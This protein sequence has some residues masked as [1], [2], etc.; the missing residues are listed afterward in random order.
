MMYIKKFL[1]QGISVLAAAALFCAVSAFPL[2]AAGAGISKVEK[3]YDIA[4]VFDNSGSMYADGSKAWCRAK[5]AM[6]IFASMLDYK[7][8]DRLTVYPMWEVTTDGSRP[9]TG[10][11]Y[12]PF[13]ITSLSDVDKISDLY[14]VHPS[15]T[16][17]APVREAYDGLKTSAASE[18]WLIVLTDGAF[19][20]RERTIWAG[21]EN[22]DLQAELSS[23]ADGNVKVQYLGIGEA[24]MLASDESK[25]FYAK[26]STDTS[27][28][29]DLISI[30]N[31]I[32][33]R[34]ELPAGYLAGNTLTL[35][36]SMRKLLVFAQGSGA[37]IVSLT[38]EN[39]RTIPVLQDSGQRKYSEIKALGYEDAAVDTDLAGQVVTFDSCPKGTYTLDC[40]GA[41]SVQVFY[42]PDVDIAIEL[43]DLEGVPID[44]FSQI[45]T[46][47]YILNYCI[48]DNVT[49]EDVT[50][51]VLMGGDVY[52]IASV[53][54]LGKDPI[55]VPN[56]GKIT[57]EPDD[58]TFITAYG[59]YLEDYTITSEG[60][61]AI[62]Q[63]LK[64]APPPAGTLRL[65]SDV[66]QPL[67]WYKTTDRDSWQPVK[68]TLSLDGA[69]LTD[70]QLD[71]LQLDIAF[72]PELSFE[73]EPVYGES[74]V[75]VY[76]KGADDTPTGFYRINAKASLFDPY[77]QE[78]SDDASSYFEIRMYDR[79]WRWLIWLVLLG[80][81]L[82]TFLFIMTRK[83]LPKS[84]MLEPR[85]T[86]FE[87]DFQ[88][89]EIENLRAAVK[90]SRK[91]KSLVI[92]TPN[93]V[94]YSAQCSARL[95]LKPI[96]KRF[97][98][99][100]DRR[101][102]VTGVSSANAYSI[103]IGAT[104]YIPDGSG[105]WIKRGVPPSA[106]SK[107]LEQDI[108]NALITIRGGTE[109]SPV[110]TLICKLRHK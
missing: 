79:F 33:R 10:G 94:D 87:L 66:T 96:D 71:E 30:C 102:R 97:T 47:D 3:T 5:Y 32:F 106:A 69:P 28:K 78:M 54:Q 46:G 24:T 37:Q 15:N 103:T 48:V 34:V 107:P 105:K 44:P 91:N 19:N 17:L 99:S 100:K 1:R 59:T 51:S 83:T 36:L 23:L 56:G 58:S 73:T 27:L 62:P 52:L 22:I 68:L 108:K 45:P 104:E 80:L 35:D 67:S 41:E 90:Y 74:A 16:P 14:T 21:E 60:T 93:E 12:A 76:I 18:K 77:G 64:I 20:E 57:L 25:G 38:D 85:S 63:P 11:S 53:R 86:R 31:S 8:G 88:D 92:S 43:T 70:E 9:E 29:D 39:G 42:D 7:G 50:N 13:E 72:S 82:L 2:N 26:K 98:K 109:E 55:E 49:G 110:S 81:A 89:E 4:V 6:E 40:S 84:V 95:T 65:S 61:D 101:I 75:N